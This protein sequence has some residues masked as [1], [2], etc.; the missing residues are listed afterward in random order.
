MCDLA[1]EHAGGTDQTIETVMKGDQVRVSCQNPN[2]DRSD[3]TCLHESAPP[4]ELSR[5]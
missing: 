1:L 2:S 3:S 5:I 4:H